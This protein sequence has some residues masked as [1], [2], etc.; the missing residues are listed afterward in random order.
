VTSLTGSF[1]FISYFLL[2]LYGKHHVVYSSLKGYDF[3]RVYTTVSSENKQDR[4]YR[5]N[6]C[7]ILQLM[8]LLRVS[9]LSGPSS[10]VREHFVEFLSC[11]IVSPT[12]HIAPLTS[13]FTVS[14]LLAIKYSF[15]SSTDSSRSQDKESHF[16]FIWLVRLLALRPLLAYCASLG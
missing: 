16:F 2:N 6:I 14:G 5:D 9:T 1:N 12:S 10:D 8:T 13:E 4:H 7:F 15:P 3:E 11:V